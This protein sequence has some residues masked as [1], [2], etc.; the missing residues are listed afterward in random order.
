MIEY[1]LKNPIGILLKN[2]QNYEH[3]NLWLKIDCQKKK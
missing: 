1:L 3:S 2:C